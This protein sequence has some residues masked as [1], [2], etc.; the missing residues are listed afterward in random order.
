MLLTSLEL[1]SKAKRF[2]D[3][4]SD[5]FILLDFLFLVLKCL[6]QKEKRTQMIDILDLR[7]TALVITDLEKVTIKL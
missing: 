6:N 4:K 2:D 1:R 5:N 3:K 7:R